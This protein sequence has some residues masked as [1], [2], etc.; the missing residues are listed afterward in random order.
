AGAGVVGR[1]GAVGGEACGAEAGG[2]GAAWVGA[3]GAG[4]ACGAGAGG[5]G[6]VWRAGAAG[7][8]ACGAGAG[9]G[10]AAWRLTLGGA[11]WR[12]DAGDGG[13]IWD[14]LGLTGRAAG[15]S[16]FTLGRATSAGWETA[17]CR[18]S[19]PGSSP[20]IALRA[21]TNPRMAS[22]SSGSVDRIPRKTSWASWARPSCSNCQA[23]TFWAGS[24]VPG[25]PGG[26]RGAG[27][28]VSLGAAGATARSLTA[29][30]RM[31]KVIVIPRRKARA[32]TRIF[33]TVN[34]RE[35]G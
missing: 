19:S 1:A 26:G 21:A 10:G 18:R 14:P 3:G 12:F 9:R 25:V 17:S 11:V 5:G 30:P 29:D 6:A 4:A 32:G 16:S 33:R 22:C 28:V 27:A 15:G 2:G 23:S 7:G 31:M 35:R 20:A 8:V 34:S 13:S 24:V